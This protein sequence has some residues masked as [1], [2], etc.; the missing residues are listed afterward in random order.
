MFFGE[1]NKNAFGLPQSNPSVVLSVRIVI[2]SNHYSILCCCEPVIV[3][4]HRLS[5]PLLFSRKSWVSVFAVTLQYMMCANDRILYNPKTVFA[6]GTL[7]HLI[8]ITIQSCLNTLR[9]QDGGTEYSVE[10]M[11]KMRWVPTT[12]L[13]V[14]CGTGDIS[15]PIFLLKMARLF[16]LRFINPRVSK[17]ST[18]QYQAAEL[19]RTPIRHNITEADLAADKFINKIR[20][21]LDGVRR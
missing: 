19:K 7:H 21:T 12:I 8:T 18:S 17:W 13:R 2:V 5:S 15:W 4:P 9:I 11:S 1:F 14:I 20:D 16:A 10:C 6:C 3:V